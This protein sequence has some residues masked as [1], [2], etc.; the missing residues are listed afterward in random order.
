MNST[1]SLKVPCFIMSCQDLSFFHCLFYLIF[2]SPF[3]TVHVLYIY[4]MAS[5]LGFLWNPKMYKWVALC[6]Y[7]L[8]WGL[9]LLFFVCLFVWLVV[10]LGLLFCF[11]VFFCLYYFSVLLFALSFILYYILILSFRNLYVF[12]FLELYI[13]LY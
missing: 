13:V 8:F 10:G 9:F 12:F 1:A 4:I 11:V 5:C 7:Y 3:L 2:Y 6:F